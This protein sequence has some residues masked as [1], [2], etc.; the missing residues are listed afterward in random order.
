MNR[1]ELKE[2]MTYLVPRIK[3]ALI[4]ENDIEPVPI[5]IPTDLEPFLLPLRT[6][7]EE[8]FIAFHLDVHNRVIGYAEISHGT[9][10]ASLVHPREVFKGALLSNANSIVVA[11]NHPGGSNVPSDHDLQTTIQLVKAG[12]ILG[13]KLLDH[14]IVTHKELVS[15]RESYEHLF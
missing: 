9:V 3:L 5:V 12:N 15:L 8:Y 13:I 1:A 11:H 10:S 14:L 2:H 6:A 7:A 4:R